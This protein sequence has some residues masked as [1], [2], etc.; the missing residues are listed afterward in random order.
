MALPTVSQNAPYTWVVIADANG[1]PLSSIP[2]GLPGGIN[3]NTDGQTATTV[4]E[5]QVGLFSPGSGIDRWRSVANGDGVN[6]GVG[7]VAPMVF[8]GTNHDR[9]QGFKS[10]AYFHDAIRQQTINATMFTSTTGKLTSGGA[11]TTG[12]SLFNTVGNTKSLYVF[13][14]RIATAAGSMHTL[15]TTTVDP[16]LATAGQGV[17]NKL[18][19]GAS[20]ANCTF[21]NV[22]T[23]AGTL[24]SSAGT[25]GNTTGNFLDN[26]III[27]VPP[28]QGI[29]ALITTST[30]NWQSTISWFEV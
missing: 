19:G 2:V 16:A 29:L 12:H 20:V 9:L 24:F 21:Q 22:A 17:N 11:I 27:V 28:G 25:G 30:N 1:N 8:N 10:A 6:V 5:T 18:G 15:N 23:S 4:P 26:G 13:S 3:A 7:Q 14:I